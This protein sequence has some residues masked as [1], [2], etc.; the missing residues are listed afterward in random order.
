M[1]CNAWNH[2]ATCE[3]GWGGQWHGSYGGGRASQSWT[4]AQI[5]SRDYFHHY[6]IPGRL[7]RIVSYT[8]PNATCPVC[9]AKVFFYQSPYGGRVFFDE[10]GP[11]WPKHPCTDNASPTFGRTGCR[12]YPAPYMPAFS[13]TPAKPQ[14]AKTGWDPVVLID[15]LE[16][17]AF[18]VLL[19]QRIENDDR[20]VLGINK[21]LKIDK[22]S[23]TFIQERDDALGVF[24]ISFLEIRD[25]RSASARETVYRNARQDSDVQDWVN[26]VAGSAESQNR[27]AL[28]LILDNDVP[29]RSAIRISDETVDFEAAAFWLQRAH[30]S[31][32]TAATANLGL[33]NTS[34]L[35]ARFGGRDEI[36]VADFR[37]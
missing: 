7:G 32:C 23:P 20:V 21:S 35:A 26:A 28:R 36:K 14:W 24:S 18:T 17:P 15:V 33:L 5:R 13:S 3:C 4:E 37:V 2:S 12:D 1:P 30:N 22:L 25:D 19:V 8:N 16:A 27:I 29:R 34:R 9:A 10:L 31:T 11:P 6:W